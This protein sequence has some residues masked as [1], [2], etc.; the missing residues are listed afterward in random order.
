MRGALIALTLAACSSFSSASTTSSD[1][2]ASTDAASS[3]A[4]LS[5]RCNGSFCTDPDASVCC[6][7]QNVTPTCT[8]K[9]AC[10]LAIQLRCDDREDCEALGFAGYQCC[11]TFRDGVDGGAQLVVTDAVCAPSCDTANKNYPLCNPGTPGSCTT[12][13]CDSSS[14]NPKGYGLCR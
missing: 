1:A 12:G 7:A 8:G 14:V 5:V 9:D 6:L 3:T 4:K 11:G 2:D 10:T 13:T